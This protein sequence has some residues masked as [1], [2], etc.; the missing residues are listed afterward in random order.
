MQE[1]RGPRGEVALFSA[2]YGYN[3]VIVNTVA[4]N[5]ILCSVPLHNYSELQP[6]LF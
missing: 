1:L 6:F 2:E 4:I 3:D 5:K